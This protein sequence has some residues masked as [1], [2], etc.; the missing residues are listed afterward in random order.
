MN[1]QDIKDTA[2]IIGCVAGGLVVL[3][4][5][6]ALVFGIPTAAIVWIIEAIQS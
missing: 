6:I 5:C 2:V 3:G 4:V 1:L